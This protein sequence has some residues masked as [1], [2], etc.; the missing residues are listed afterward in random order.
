MKKEL[1]EEAFAGSSKSTE[2]NIP[3]NSKSCG[4]TKIISSLHSL[5]DL[6]DQDITLKMNLNEPKL[7]FYGVS[8]E[9]LR[10]IIENSF[11][12]ELEKYYGESQQSHNIFILKI[13]T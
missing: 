2:I 7:L 13:K 6:C 8:K 12:P 1:E 11:L 5:V 9:Y 3:F 4:F 10:L